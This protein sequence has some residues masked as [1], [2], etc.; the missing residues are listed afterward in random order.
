MRVLA[1]IALAATCVAGPVAAF[2]A[3]GIARSAWD[4]FK[5]GCG[6]AVT[7]PQGYLNGAPA[8]APAGTQPVASSPDGKVVT[9]ML[10]RNGVEER[11]QFLGFS[12]RM[13]IFCHVS[14]HDVM[15]QSGMSAELTEQFLANP[16]LM[17]DP[18]FLARMQRDMS[19]AVMPDLRAADTAIGTAFGQL[20]AAD[21]S[22]TVSGGAVPLTPMETY[23]AP[24]FGEQHV[25]PEQNYHGF[26]IET[27]FGDVPVH[28][29]A[30]VQYGGL[31]IGLSHTI[32]GDQ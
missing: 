28:A 1:L 16:D 3:M 23:V 13:V 17:N 20:L 24:L 19:G 22:V 18:D 8:A 21:P 15:A 6:Q 4:G 11:V 30:E 31:W 14:A 7:D 5:A 26:A 2:D 27:R 25:M 29:T 10:L 32:G 12:D 9:A